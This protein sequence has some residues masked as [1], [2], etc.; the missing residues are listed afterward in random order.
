MLTRGSVTVAL[1]VARAPN[2]AVPRLRPEALAAAIAATRATEEAAAG[3]GLG[4]SLLLV[5][6]AP[7]VIVVGYETTGHRHMAAVLQRV[8][9]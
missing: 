7:A 5:T 2:S 3:A 8:L 1:R 9:G 4:A 6:L